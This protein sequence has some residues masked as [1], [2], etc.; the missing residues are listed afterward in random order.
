LGHVLRKNN[1]ET[2]RTVTEWK[3]QERWIEDGFKNIGS[4]KLKKK[5]LETEFEVPAEILRE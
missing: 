1:S 4:G 3:P 2:L 5:L